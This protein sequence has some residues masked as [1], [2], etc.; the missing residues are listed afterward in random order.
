MRRIAIA[1]SVLCMTQVAAAQENIVI[2]RQGSIAVGGTV[3]QR[4]GEYNNSQFGG[5][6]T[7]IE[8]GQSYHADHAVADFQ[9]PADAHKL[10]LVLVHGFGQ[11]ARCWTTTP[12]GREGFSTLLLRNKLSTY[13]VDLPGRGRAGR[14]TAQTSIK[15]QADE[16]QWF[17]IFRIG[18][19]PNY[20]KGVQF[21]TDSASMEQFFR[22]M[23]PDIST[24]DKDVPALDTLFDKIGDG[25]LVTHS[26]SGFTGW[27]T[28]LQNPS[29]KA[30]ASYE[31][32]NYVFPENEV[33]ESM[34]SLTGTLKGAEVPMSEFMKLTKIPIVL[35]FGDY[36]PE[37]VTDKIGGENWRVRLQLGR[38]FVEAINRHGG[39]ATLV[40]LPKIGIEGNTH[41][42][43]S[44]LNNVQIANQLVDWL[45]AKGLV[46]LEESTRTI[47]Q[48]EQEI[49][50]LSKTK[51]QWMS[52]R[53]VDSLQV[54]FHDNAVF[55]HMGGAMDKEQE[56][57][58]IKVGG[59]H[60]KKADIFEQSVRFAGETAILLGR[61]RLLAVVGGREVTN[62]F[63]V[64]ETYIKEKSVW[65]LA[66]LS[67]TRLLGRS[68]FEENHL[69]RKDSPSS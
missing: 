25:I 52:E 19:W 5:W 9:I 61:I 22:Q 24:H 58:V 14:T 35:Y 28:A 26:A 34:P 67:F 17:D 47:V 49:L 1:L 7:P 31:P 54:L 44:D 41:F 59:I 27:L 38:K 53:K 8:T 18:E 42:P 62:P 50:N 11:S 3:I 36:I 48:R 23:T 4:S 10:P 64:T 57:G 2:Q 12:D 45:E 60:Y 69:I 15:P 13:I 21:P 68:L 30:I 16:Q 40:E 55:V 39:D 32:G 46:R 6:G 43:M 20:N 66:S 33:P 29:V 63:I 56:L 51:W 65:K 37:E